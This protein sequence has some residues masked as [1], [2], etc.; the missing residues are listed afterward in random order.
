MKVGDLSAFK[1]TLKTEPAGDA[2]TAAASTPRCKPR[3]QKH[4]DFLQSG[5]TTEEAAPSSP[6]VTFEKPVIGRLPRDGLPI[7]RAGGGGAEA[8]RP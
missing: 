2:M 7:V 5:Q 3:L 6:N 8:K 4:A 1:L